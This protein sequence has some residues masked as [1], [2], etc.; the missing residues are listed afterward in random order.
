MS[1]YV[2]KIRTE[3]GDLPIDYNALANHPTISNPNLLLNSDFRSPINQRCSTVYEGNSARVY[4]IDRWCHAATDFG[5]TIE[6]CDGH[7]RYTNPNETYQSF[8]LQQFERALPEDDYT[9]TVAVKSVSGNNVC[10]GNLINGA[11][12]V[13]WGN[14]SCFNLR[15]GINTFTFHGGC[16]GLYFQAS[17]L[18]AA[19]LYWVK[20]EVGTTS[21]KFCPRMFQ[22]ELF[23]CRRYF[24]AMNGIRVIGAERDTNAKTISFAIPRTMQM[25]S[26]PKISTRGTTTENSTEGICVRNTE[27]GLLTGFTFTYEVRNWELL[28]VAHYNT[29]LD[30]EA[31]QAQLYIDD[32]FLICLDA[33]IY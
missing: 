14:L 9:I 6:V 31:H 18:S 7:V 26:I 22:E 30:R 11:N 21:T 3:A 32:D 4:T 8:W 24:D 19:E 12:G 1:Q 33:E 29:D 2:T 10:V 27:C 23:L 28:V 17:I 25:R 20:L 16:A 5:R 13:E 15:P